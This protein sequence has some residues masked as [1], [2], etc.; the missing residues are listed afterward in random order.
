MEIWK[1]ISGY[2]GLYQASSFGRILSLKRGI[3][4]KQQLNPSGYYYVALSKD[5]KAKRFLVSR[6][7]A[8]TFIPNP[9]NLPEVNHKDENTKNNVVENLE[10]CDQAYNNT[11]GTRIKRVCNTIRKQR[12]CRPIIQIDGDKVVKWDCIG[13][14]AKQLGFNKACIYR[15]CI[16]K[17]KF[18]KGYRWEYAS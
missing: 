11:Y 12:N 1:D 6:L 14:A 2:E 15:V 5:G 13:E 7:I 16:N 4:L 9:D 10:W 18:Y 17:R 3:I 8:K